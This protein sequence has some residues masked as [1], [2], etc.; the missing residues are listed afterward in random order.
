M[1]E[2]IPTA[3]D[4]NYYQSKYTL[5]CRQKHSWISLRKQAASQMYHLMLSSFSTGAQS[6]W[7]CLAYVPTNYLK[8]HTACCSPCRSTRHFSVYVLHTL[9]VSTGEKSFQPRVVKHSYV[10]QPW[11]KY[12]KPEGYPVSDCKQEGYFS[13]FFFFLRTIN[14]SQ[15]DLLYSIQTSKEISKMSL[16]LL[17]ALFGL[18]IPGRNL[19]GMASTFRQNPWFSLQKGFSCRV[20]LYIHIQ[21]FIYT[22]QKKKKTTKKKSNQQPPHTTK[23]NLFHKP[24][25]IILFSKK[26]F[27]YKN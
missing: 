22:H 6:C 13:P 5:S 10:C 4:C 2:R 25:S 9:T 23:T 24:Y 8:K 15:K 17:P 26:Q 16:W 14:Q 3:Q 12:Q 20:F 11:T 7:S 21:I 27:Y 18:H 19:C 1:S